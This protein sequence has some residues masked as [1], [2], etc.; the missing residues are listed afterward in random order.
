MFE[1]RPYQEKAL[2]LI[3]GE[4]SKQNKKVL[5]HLATGAGK[6]VIFCQILKSASAKGK[7]AIMVVRGR[8]LVN[9]ASNRLERE[10]V[11]HGV[12]MA[13]HKKFRPHE[14]IQVCSI[15]TLLARDIKPEADIIVIDEAHLALS[16]GYKEFLMKYPNAYILSVTATPYNDQSLRHLADVVVSPISVKELIE[17]GHLAPPKYFTHN[18]PDLKGV[19]TTNTKDGKDY[20]QS[21]LE[22]VMDAPAIMG[23]IA[24]TW[25]EKAKGRP[26]L[27]F[28]VSVAHS[29]H[30]AEYLNSMGIRAAHVDASS[31][32]KERESFISMLENGELDILCN[33]G[34]L[35]TGVDIPAVSAII[36]ARPTKSKNLH[37]QQMGRGTRNSAGKSDFLVLDHAG[38]VL[39]HKFLTTEHEVNLDAK[40]KT[41]KIKVDGVKQCDV[42]FGVFEMGVKVCPYCGNEK[43]TTL[44]TINTV[45][46]ELKEIKP[47]DIDPVEVFIKKMKEIQKARGYKRGWVYFQ[48]V[49]KFGEETANK[50]MPKRFVPHWVTRGA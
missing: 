38:N 9:Q 49:E 46:G 5:L 6:T 4:Y 34:I 20:V 16:G 7:K 24:T 40:E 18:V 30:L 47:E 25:L 10:G 17:Q 27:A 35:C 3:R 21:Q 14:K 45:D 44:R 26:T 39:K 32:D 36:L 48:L 1:L 23:D 31:S 19:K 28:C 43:E 33:C 13:G 29:Q 42:C 22:G 12:M 15:D 37:I 8:K 11:S 41:K 50:Y 2:D